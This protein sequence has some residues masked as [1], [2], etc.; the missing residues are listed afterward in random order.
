MFPKLIL[1]FPVTELASSEHNSNFIV[2]A[3][4]ISPHM[5]LQEHL[6]LRMFKNFILFCPEQLHSQLVSNS[7]HLPFKLDINWIQNFQRTT[8]EIEI[9]TQ[10]V[11]LLLKDAS[12]RN[13]CYAFAY[14]LNCFL[15]I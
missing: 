3:T 5:N 10:L 2:V 15:T 7:Y 13:H 14:H 12:L 6:K 11:S 4:L 8:A 1:I 9:Y